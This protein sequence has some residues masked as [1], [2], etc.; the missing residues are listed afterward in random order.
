M[1]KALAM[2]RKLFWFAA[3]AVTLMA[4]PVSARADDCLDT[5]KTFAM[6]QEM[7]NGC[8]GWGLTEFGLRRYVDVGSKLEKLDGQRCAKLGNAAMYRTLIEMNPEI[9]KLAQAKDLPRFSTAVCET[10]ALRFEMM[11][12]MAGGKPIIQRK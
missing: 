3:M 7:Y 10:L 4:A 6:M 11:T 1:V 8:P 2:G 12:Q 9:E 5:G